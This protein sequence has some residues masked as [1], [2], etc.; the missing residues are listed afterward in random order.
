[1]IQ[2]VYGGRGAQ[3]LYL[4][5]SG[6]TFL[7]LSRDLDAFDD[8]V[9]FFREYARHHHLI[10]ATRDDWGDW[11][12]TGGDSARRAISHDWPKRRRI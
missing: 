11:K 3:L 8:L 9:G 1:M 10:F 12:Q 7:T 4:R 2:H 6:R 5:H